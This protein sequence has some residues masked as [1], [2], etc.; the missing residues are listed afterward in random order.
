MFKCDMCGACC[1]NIGG[2][3]LY[4]DLDNGFGICKYLIGNKC[5][6][7]EIR[8]LFCRV[9]ESYEL[10]FK[11]FVDKVTFYNQNYIICKKLKEKEGL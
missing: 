8:P 2:I 3:D 4:K 1:R 7:Y 5:L 6:I 11:G 10:F 9:D